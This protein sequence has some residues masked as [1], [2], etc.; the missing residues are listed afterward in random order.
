MV[1]SGERLLFL[2]GGRKYHH[3]FDFQPSLFTSVAVQ[4]HGC[5]CSGCRCGPGPCKS[6]SGCGMLQRSLV[7]SRLQHLS[8][9]FRLLLWRLS[10]W[11]PSMRKFQ[12]SLAASKQQ[13]Y[14]QGRFPELVWP[15]NVLFWFVVKR[16]KGT[17]GSWNPRQQ[18]SK[19][20]ILSYIYMGCFLG[21]TVLN[22]FFSQS[23]TKHPLS[24]VMPI[25]P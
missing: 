6:E 9:G 5:V 19:P 2:R 16:R 22:L 13:R 7:Q 18:R 20:F 10:K 12:C 21:F 3:G 11:I 25:G 1:E 23:W 17:F 8:Q 4:M 24:Q 14:A 15:Q